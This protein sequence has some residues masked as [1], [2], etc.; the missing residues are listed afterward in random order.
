MFLTDLGSLEL[1]YR[2]VGWN[3]HVHV[4]LPLPVSVGPLAQ[5]KQ[6][7]RKDLQEVLFPQAWKWSSQDA[8]KMSLLQG[9][10]GSQ[11]VSVCKPLFGKNRLAF[12]T[13]ELQFCS[14]DQNSR[15]RA[16]HL[17]CPL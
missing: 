14:E 7:L 9:K 8:G 17:P 13:G 2:A 16:E 11:P 1:S 12:P 6:P 3:R 4:V 5:G 10:R 15:V